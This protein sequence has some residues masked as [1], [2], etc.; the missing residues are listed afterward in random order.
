MSINY[1]MHNEGSTNNLI[2]A[3]TLKRQ[4][5]PYRPNRALHLLSANSMLGNACAPK[6]AKP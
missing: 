1:A 3:K 4:R 6:Q 2:F 5:L